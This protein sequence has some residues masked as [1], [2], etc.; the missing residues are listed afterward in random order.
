MGVGTQPVRQQRSAPGLLRTDRLLRRQLGLSRSSGPALLPAKELATHLKHAKT[1]RGHRAAVYCITFDRSGAT[2]ITGSDDR[3][4]KVCM[5]LWPSH[6]LMW[7]KQSDYMAMYPAAWRMKFCGMSSASSA[8][9]IAV[10]FIN[11]SI[12]GADKRLG[13]APHCHAA[14]R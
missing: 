6:N 7:R 4:V 3:L 11:F 8:R 9:P 1:S 14:I 10:C 13:K 12:T 5:H 2:I